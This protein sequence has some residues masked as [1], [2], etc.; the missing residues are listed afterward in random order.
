MRSEYEVQLFERETRAHFGLLLWG[1]FCLRYLSYEKTIQKDCKNDNYNSRLKSFR[2]V[3]RIQ[4]LHDHFSKA[5][6]SDESGNN[7]HGK[8]KHY[9][10]GYSCTNRR[11]CIW[12]FYLPKALPAGRA[13][14]IRY[15][16]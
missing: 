9:A 3:Y 1:C 14:G 15:F 8:R 11:Q 2:N 5:I 4:G 6:G 16:P 7:D 13:K 12:Y 10:L